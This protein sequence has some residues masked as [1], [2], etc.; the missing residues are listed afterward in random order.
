FAL[1]QGEL[2]L[3]IIE[4]FDMLLNLRKYPKKFGNSIFLT[5]VDLTYVWQ[6]YPETQDFIGKLLLDEVSYKEKMKIHKDYMTKIEILGS[7]EDKKE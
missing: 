7:L 6:K 5:A 1:R 2:T 3:D 4:V